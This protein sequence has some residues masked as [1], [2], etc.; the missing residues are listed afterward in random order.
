M[1]G[2]VGRQQH[3]VR[4]FYAPIS[5]TFAIFETAQHDSNQNTQFKQG[6][7]LIL[8]ECCKTWENL[9]NLEKYWYI[10]LQQKDA[11]SLHS[12]ILVYSGLSRVPFLAK[13]FKQPTE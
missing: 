11:Q 3:I 13:T 12:L 1:Q 2:H 9:S 6:F 7:L 8:V 5:R 10:L 4:K